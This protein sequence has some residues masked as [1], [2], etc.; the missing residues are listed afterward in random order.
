MYMK[1][2][3]L[4]SHLKG[5]WLPA[6]EGKDIKRKPKNLDITTGIKYLQSVSVLLSW[7]YSVIIACCSPFQ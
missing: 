2:F 3:L 4:A 5:W 6:D 7:G 1:G